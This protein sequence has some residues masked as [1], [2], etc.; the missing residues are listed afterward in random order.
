M[1]KRRM[2]VNEKK[3]KKRKRKRKERGKRRDEETMR[4]QCGGSWRVG[5]PPAALGPW[6]VLEEDWR[7]AIKLSGSI[8][9]ATMA[10]FG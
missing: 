2:K 1:R 9:T 4:F 10:H 3:T 7:N 6:L 8:Q 5:S